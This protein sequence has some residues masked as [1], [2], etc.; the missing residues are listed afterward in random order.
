MT[1]IL[2]AL[3]GAVVA[4]ILAYWFGSKKAVADGEAVRAKAE[5]EGRAAAEKLE[6]TAKLE[7]DAI[8]K[9][10]QLDAEEAR[11]KAEREAE[12]E[13]RGKRQELDKLEEKVAERQTKL[14]ERAIALDKK[15]NDLSEQEKSVGRKQ[16]LL[17]DRT[18]SLSEREGEADKKLAE[19]AGI[20]AEEARARVIESVAESARAE[21]A[22]AARQIE[23]SAIEEADKRA[24]KVLAV[25][26]Q[27]L[28]GEFV[29]ERCVSVIH[30]ANE[31]LKGRII[32]REGRNIRAIEAATGVDFIID[33]TPEAIIISAFDPVR[34]EIAKRAVERML[35]DG[36]IHPSR[37]EEVVQKSTNEMDRVMRDAGEQACFELGLT[38][39]SG[40]T[41]R[42][43][44]RL[45][46]RTSYGQNLLSHS[47]QVGWLTGLMADELG[48]NG[49]LARRCGF[50]HD[51]GKGLDH[52]VTLAQEAGGGHALVGA[53]FL[54]KGGEDET[55]VNA[56]ASH[57]GEVKPATVYAHLVMAANE[58]S[59][60]RPGARREALEGFVQR[61][62]DLERIALSF[63]GVDKAYAVQAGREVRVMV[64]HATIS[65]DG[66]YQLTKE[67]ARKIEE[68]LTYPGQ[69]LVSVIR[70]TRAESTAR[71]KMSL[72]TPS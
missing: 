47:L 9:R 60:S 18:K 33:D 48:L 56:A 54:K 72:R 5:A 55:V 29:T 51:I 64:E 24:K 37:I 31:E 21:A 12:R 62:G 39:L 66:A 34:R 45:K 1:T 49:K 40:D 65:D 44:G 61:L 22:K 53:M 46:F 7:A 15:Q 67:I 13:S 52:D 4:G 70:E 38:G 11:I 23:E 58:L 41:L 8:K 43:M 20:S 68:E 30:L 42:A 2:A 27:R 50:L 16:T 17:D 32:G 28:A 59:G 3:A 25:A 14:D 35:A 69:I 6:A 71:G 26:M 57:H 10:A 36:R 19:I 63:K